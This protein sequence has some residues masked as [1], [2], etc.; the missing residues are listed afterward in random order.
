MANSLSGI[1]VENIRKI[2]CLE[3]AMPFRRLQITKNYLNVNFVYNK[4]S[5]SCRITIFPNYSTNLKKKNIMYYNGSISIF[6]IADMKIANF[7]TKCYYREYTQHLRSEQPRC[8]LC[9]FFNQ[10]KL[11]SNAPSFM[12][13]S[14]Y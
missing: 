5:S 4:S 7:S 10:S 6:F 11:I 2:V 8:A 3:N 9:S 13:M 14:W 12:V 1:T